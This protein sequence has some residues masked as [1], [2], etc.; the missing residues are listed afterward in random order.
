MEIKELSRDNYHLIKEMWAKLNRLH[1]ELSNNFKNHFES[2]TF[3]KRMQPLFEK[4]HLSVFIATDTTEHVGYCIVSAENGKGEIDSIYIEPE[5]RKQGIGSAFVKHRFS[6]FENI[7][8]KQP[9]LECMP[10]I[11]Y[12]MN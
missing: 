10:N 1:G 11:K 7:L 3:E 9:S 6:R 2:F 8:N 12:I 4:K 5:F